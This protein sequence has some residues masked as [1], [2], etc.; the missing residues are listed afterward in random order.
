MNIYEVAEGLRKKEFI[1]AYALNPAKK[2][3]FLV[4]YSDDPERFADVIV[5]Y[6][7]TL[8]ESSGEEENY[9]V[10]E[11]IDEFDYAE[12]LRFVPLAKES[13]EVLNLIYNYAVNLLK[14]NELK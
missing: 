6:S 5:N 9:A 14:S 4:D 11:F 10:D 13:Y 7:R 3:I 1:Q 12:D 2:E 8:S